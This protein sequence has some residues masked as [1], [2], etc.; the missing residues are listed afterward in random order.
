M[1]EYIL[2]DILHFHLLKMNESIYFV[3]TIQIEG[4]KPVYVSKDSKTPGHQSEFTVETAVADGVW[5][6]LS[7]F[8]NG[9]NT[10]LLLDGEEVMSTTDKTL[11]LSPVSVDKIVLGAAPGDSNLQLS[12][13]LLI[14]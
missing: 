8:N 2:I 13:G 12:G 11:D 10:F 3:S 4:K 9:H 14:L 5:H 6:D 7:L 1:I